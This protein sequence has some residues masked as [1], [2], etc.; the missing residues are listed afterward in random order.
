MS[1]DYTNLERTAG[2]VR[3][4]LAGLVDKETAENLAQIR[5]VLSSVRHASHMLAGGANEAVTLQDLGLNLTLIKPVQGRELL[6]SQLNDAEA[7]HG[8]ALAE[9]LNLKRG[10]NGRYATAWGDKTS[11]GLYATIKRAIM[12]LDQGGAI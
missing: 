12:T 4:S 3:D 11:Q 7:R 9:L 10:A 5:N 8:R 1:A 2:R 6:A